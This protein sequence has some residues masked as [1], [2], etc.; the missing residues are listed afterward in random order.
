MAI[1]FLLILAVMA[2]IAVGV[3]VGVVMLLA[4]SKTR[5]VGLALLAIP[6]VLLLPLL[7]FVGLFSVRSSVRSVEHTRS[8]VNQRARCMEVSAAGDCAF[9]K[10]A[11]VAAVDDKRVDAE[12]TNGNADTGKKEKAAKK[13]NKKASPPAA[14]AAETSNTKEPPDWVT[15]GQRKDGDLYKWPVTV[16][17]WPT[18]RE[19][20]GELPEVLDRAVSQYAEKKLKLVPWAARRVRLPR[21]YVLGELLTAQW[22]KPVAVSSETW[23]ELHALLEFDAE[24]NS[25]ILQQRQQAIITGRLWGVGAVVAAVLLLLSTLFAYLKIDLATGGS[26]RGRLRFAAAT[27]ILAVTAI[28]A[29]LVVS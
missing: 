29:L 26:Y 3:I 7:L 12:A 10:V 17:A 11:V 28:G 14:K 6:L 23:V 4:N 18:L 24:A 15:A 8:V 20:Q 22:H 5:P 25:R 27:V 21:D 2:V 16:Q 1:G 9:P 19:C 13:E